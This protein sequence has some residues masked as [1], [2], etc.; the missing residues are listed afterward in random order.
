MTI[1]VEELKKL[2]W[3]DEL[4]HAFIVPNTFPVLESAIKYTTPEPQCVDSATL[5]ISDQQE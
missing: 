1:A 5:V 2:G 3:S 4:I